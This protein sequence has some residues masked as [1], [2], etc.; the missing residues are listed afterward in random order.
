MLTHTRRDLL[1]WSWLLLAGPCVGGHGHLPCHAGCG[2]GAWGAPALLLCAV[3]APSH[4]PPVYCM[5]SIAMAARSAFVLPGVT[6][7]S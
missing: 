4:A 6:A 3:C 2:S 5:R 7:R 1:A